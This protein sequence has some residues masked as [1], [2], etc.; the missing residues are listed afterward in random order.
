VLLHDRPTQPDDGWWPRPVSYL[1]RS[2][3]PASGQPYD[4]VF[5]WSG[6]QSLQ[7]VSHGGGSKFFQ[8]APVV[9]NN[10]LVPGRESVPGQGVVILGG[11]LDRM[12]VNDAVYLAWMPLDH[13]PALSSIRYYTGRADQPWS[14]KEADARPLWLLLPIYTSMSLTYVSQAQ[15]WIA[16]Y[17]K[18]AGV[19]RTDEGVVILDRVRGSI[20]A[21]VA[22]VPTGPWSREIVVF[23]PC[24][25]WAFGDFMHWPGLDVLNEQAFP[26]DSQPGWAYGAFILAPLTHWHPEDRTITVYYLM[27]TSRPYHVQFMSSRFKID[28]GP[29]QMDWRFCGK[30]HAL[31]FDGY[32]TKGVCPAE[33]SHQAIGYNFVLPHDISEN[34][35]R[36][37]FWAFCDKCQSMFFN[38]YP[39]K[40]TC[41]TQGSHHAAGYDFVL[42]H[43]L[44]EN[45][46][47][48]GQWRFC[49]KCYSM[50]FDGYL[51][52]G[53]CP[54]EGSHQP[55]GYDFVLAH[56]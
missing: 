56:T 9:V 51:N 29:E 17:S 55:A 14:D 15:R 23:D 28:P 30:C 32:A 1:T 22:T 2:A 45:D 46:Q 4:E 48:R 8:V 40:G 34:P 35:H 33:G 27:S 25:E 12:G 19:T 54:A 11:G 37:R 21:R 26:S 16:L 13:I 3:N 10:T 6:G 36:Q 43:D 52:K 31:F 39:S 38:G 41:A 50:F 5:R 20:V 7:E 18:A 53:V 24:R 47:Q 49:E 44:C 42:P